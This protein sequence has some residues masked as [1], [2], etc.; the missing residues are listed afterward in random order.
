[1]ARKLSSV[2]SYRA[3]M[4]QNVLILQKKLSTRWRHLYMSMSQGIGVFRL[5]NGDSPSNANK[6]QV[7]AR[8]KASDCVI[9]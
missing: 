3:A 6:P 1:M 5:D 7:G 9:P 4:R 8:T 2:L